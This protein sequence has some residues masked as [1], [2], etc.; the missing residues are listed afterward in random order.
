MFKSSRVFLR[1][2]RQLQSLAQQGSRGAACGLH[3]AAAAGKFSST[4]PVYGAG[5]AVLMVAGAAMLGFAPSVL[6]D[7]PACLEREELSFIM[8][9]PDGVQRGLIS[10]IIARFE[11]K[12]YKLVGIKVLVP[13]QALAAKHY[14]EH[15]GKP[16]FPKLVNFLSSGPVVAMVWEGKSVVKYGR[17]MIGATN[18]LASSPGTIR[19]DYG[20]DTGRNIIHGSDSVEA[21][22]AKHYAEHDGKPFFPKLVNFLSSGPVVAMVWEGKSVVKYGRTMI[23][24]TNPL[25]SPP[26]TIRG[27]YGIDTGRNIIH[28][29]DSVEVRGGPVVAMVWEGK[30]VVKYGRTMIGATNPL[31]S[32]PGTIRGDYGID[33]GRNI[34]H[35]SDSVESAQREIALWFK[36]EELADYTPSTAAWVYE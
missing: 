19:G 1:A 18:P 7:A 17:T 8:I 26:G 4:R 31:A 21:L 2:A 13:T 3:S 24:A 6:A 5:A 28:G 25:A 15:D 10:D 29:S 27:D 30:S 12:G 9:K 36:A 20:I 22:A 32:P 33:T 23:G 14:A 35:G 11:R 16:F 34:I